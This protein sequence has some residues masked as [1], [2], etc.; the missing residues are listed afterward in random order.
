[1]RLIEQARRVRARGMLT[2]ARIVTTDAEIGMRVSETTPAHLPVEFEATN[3][4]VKVLRYDGFM[5]L[6]P[7]ERHCKDRLQ[8]S[9]AT[10]A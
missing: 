3:L 2:M 6:L 9:A 7:A 1:M 4:P 5:R 8:G 10:S